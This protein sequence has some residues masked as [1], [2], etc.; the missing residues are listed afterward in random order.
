MDVSRQRSKDVGEYLGEILFLYL[1]TVCDDADK[2]YPTTWHGITN[3]THWSFED[4]AAFEGTEKQK[5][6][7]FR[8]VR[9]QIDIKIKR[10]LAC[11][12]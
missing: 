4:P 7:K 9:E 12:A 6:A 2:N 10:W 5:I 8:Q 1:I 11:Q 3:R